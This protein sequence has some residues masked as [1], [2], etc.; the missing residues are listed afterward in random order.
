MCCV[1]CAGRGGFLQLRDPGGAG[2]KVGAPAGLGWGRGWDG[3]DGAGLGW[4]RGWPRWVRAT[5]RAQQRP[6]CARGA[7]LA[8]P[9]PQFTATFSL[10]CKTAELKAFLYN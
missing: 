10:S 7:V 4:G 2:G 3:E 1:H 8:S 9:C 6:P 5:L